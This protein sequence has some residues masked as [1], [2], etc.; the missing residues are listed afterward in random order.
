MT[1]RQRLP[2]SA[3]ALM[4]RVAKWTRR[5]AADPAAACSIRSD[6]VQDAWQE[7]GKPLEVNAP[8][9]PT[10]IPLRQPLFPVRDHAIPGQEFSRL[11]RM[12][13]DL[14]PDQ[15]RAHLLAVR[16]LIHARQARHEAAGKAFAD[17]LALNPRL[18][19]A[20]LPTFWDL[21]RGGCDA[22]VGAY[23]HHGLTA[24]ATTLNARVRQTLRPRPLPSRE[25]SALR[26]AN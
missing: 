24:E 23:L 1:E 7:F 5:R 20:D 17:A 8:V 11:L 18:E 12:P 10:P 9:P 14:G 3:T 2:F 13:T 16:G 25:K 6:G 21:P 19:L 26:R 4:A 22:A 15:R